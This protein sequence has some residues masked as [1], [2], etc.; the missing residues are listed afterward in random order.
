MPRPVAMLA[1]M[2]LTDAT[3]PIRMSRDFGETKIADEF[4]P[5]SPVIGV[6]AY[7]EFEHRY[8]GRS[9]RLAFIQVSS[10]TEV[11]LSVTSGGRSR[12]LAIA[13]AGARVWQATRSFETLIRPSCKPV[14]ALE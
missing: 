13:S 4:L 5:C 11:A 7:P 9:I 3:V 1:R 12:K 10:R 2:R 14:S 6:L 8:L